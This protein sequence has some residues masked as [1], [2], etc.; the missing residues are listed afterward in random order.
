MKTNAIIKKFKKISCTE[1]NLQIE[2]V[3]EL[4]SCY[5][6]GDAPTT[7]AFETCP[8]CFITEL[9]GKYGGHMDCNICLWEI[10]EEETCDDYSGRLF[11]TPSSYVSHTKKWR[12]VRIPMLRRWKKILKTESRRL[13][14]NEQWGC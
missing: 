9:Y 8:L 13:S 1:L 5:K 11:N 4:L 10:L 7:S 3:D 14:K 12:K 2:T 6:R